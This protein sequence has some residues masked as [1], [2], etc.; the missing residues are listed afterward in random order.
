MPETEQRQSR[1]SRDDVALAALRILDELGL[2]DLTMRKLAST[3]T[4]QP[5]ALYW[6]FPNK[7]TLLADVADRIVSRVATPAPSD[8]STEVELIAVSLRDA[9]LTYR[10][11]AEVVSSSFALGLG[12]TRP[13]ALL[14][15][16]IANGGHSHDVAHKAATAIMHFALGHVL[17]EQ[18]RLQYSSAGVEVA[19]KG[20]GSQEFR[21][22]VE[23]LARGLGA[24]EPATTQ[25]E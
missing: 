3:L 21:F 6:H 8:W 19:G 5:S 16:A 1:H 23:L 15:T 25:A 14:E 9:L 11:G 12:G 18:Q 7:Q 13:V 24:L 17:H 10:D 4:V 2:P 22:G 20:A